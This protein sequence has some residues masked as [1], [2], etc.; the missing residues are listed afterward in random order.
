M[1]LNKRFIRATVAALCLVLVT[2][3]AQAWIIPALAATGRFLAGPITNTVMWLGRTAAA[4]PTM[5]KAAEWS[6]AAHGAIIGALWFGKSDQTA[7]TP[8]EAKIVIAPKKDQPTVNPDPKKFD[9]TASSS[10]PLQ[11]APKS[12][13]SSV[14]STTVRPSTYPLIVQAIGGEGESQWYQDT[15]NQDIRYLAM[16]APDY[17]QNGTT[18]TNS[19]SA[20]SLATVPTGYD[21]K[22]WCGNVT[23][24]TNPGNYVVYYDQKTRARPR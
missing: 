5:A 15:V 3:A 13:F 19:C 14:E 24:V 17:V 2:Q 23:G 18:Y 16:R 4:N 12:S 21:Y 6:I 7:S 22:G 11:P 20:P 1:R 9:D 10:D 8:I